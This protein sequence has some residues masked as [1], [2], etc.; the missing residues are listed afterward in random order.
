MDRVTKLREEFEKEFGKDLTPR[1][2]WVL[3]K[4]AKHVRLRCRNNAA[5]NN[6]AN[7]LFPNARFQQVTK[8]HP[9]GTYR[10]GVNVSG[11]SYPGLKITVKDQ[12][13][14][15]GDEESED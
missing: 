3:V 6:F 14:E 11:Q 15:S 4:F 5:F 9:E 1:Q 8:T 2:L 7:Q 13:V 10:R 12:S